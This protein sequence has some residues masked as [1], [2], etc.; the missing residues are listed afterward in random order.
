MGMG[1]FQVSYEVLASLL[2]LPEGSRLQYVAPTFAYGA[3]SFQVVVSH[4]DIPQ[5]T[6]P[7]AHGLRALRPSWRTRTSAV[8]VNWGIQGRD[9]K[10]VDVADE[11]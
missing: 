7:E 10:D 3:D 1:C 8:F 2:A 6:K 9:D 11:S 5:E 4:E